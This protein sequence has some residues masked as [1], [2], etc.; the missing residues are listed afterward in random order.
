MTTKE[1]GFKNNDIEEINKHLNAVI[2][3]VG[4]Y[5]KDSQ[6]FYGFGNMELMSF[7]NSVVHMR[8]FLAS[9]NEMIHDTKGD[10]VLE[11]INTFYNNA[12]AIYREGLRFNFHAGYCYYFACM[13]EK[14]F[15]GGQVVWCAPFGHIAYDYNNKIYDCEGLYNGEAAF[16]IPVENL[17]KY[18]DDFKHVGGKDKGTYGICNTE[19]ERIINDYRKENTQACIDK[20]MPFKGKGAEALKNGLSRQDLMFSYQCLIEY[21]ERYKDINEIA[22]DLYI[23]VMSGQFGFKPYKRDSVQNIYS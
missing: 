4:K 5:D 2:D 13:L 9:P 22:M 10:V 15:P 23:G 14:A 8:D 16:F 11:F 12:P 21:F 18:I 20:L 19:I 3:I 7:Y 1:I 17:G 6:R